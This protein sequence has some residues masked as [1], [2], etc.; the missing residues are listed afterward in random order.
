MRT[1]QVVCVSYFEFMYA[2]LFIFARTIFHSSLLEP[3]RKKTNLAKISLHLECSMRVHSYSLFCSFSF[4]YSSIIISVQTTSI[5]ASHQAQAK[6]VKFIIIINICLYDCYHLSSLLIFEASRDGVQAA[7]HH[8]LF[9]RIFPLAR[10]LLLTAHRADNTLWYFAFF[11]STVWFIHCHFTVSFYLEMYLNF[12]TY[13]YFLSSSIWCQGFFSFTGLVCEFSYFKMIFQLSCLKLALFSWFNKNALW[14][15]VTRR[16][17]AAN[18]RF[19]ST[20]QNI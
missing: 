13:T 9:A 16:S 4:V 6:K 12:H 2:Y 1:C 10:L 3:K 15:W 7:Q 11:P 8:Q 5:P 18:E 19:F 14:R 17:D 20:F